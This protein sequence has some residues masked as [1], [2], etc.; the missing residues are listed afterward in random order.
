MCSSD[1]IALYVETL[2]SSNAYENSYVIFDGIRI[3]NENTENPLYGMVC[4]AP[5]KNS[6]DDGLPII[7]IENSQGYIE[8]R[9]GV[10]IF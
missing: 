1:L 6:N 4:Y 2:N 8:Y 5:F 9:M 3:D 7:K 10:S